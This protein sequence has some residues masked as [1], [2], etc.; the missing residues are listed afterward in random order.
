MAKCPIRKSRVD[1][2]KMHPKW[3]DKQMDGQTGLVLYEPF[4]KDGDLITFFRNS[5]IKLS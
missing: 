3:T 4:H 5:K 1:S 2:E